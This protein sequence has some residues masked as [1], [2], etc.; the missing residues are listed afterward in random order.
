MKHFIYIVIAVLIGINNIFINY[1]VSLISYERLLEFMIFGMF[2]KSFLDEYRQ[3]GYFRKYTHYI[4]LFAV[5]QLL[6][7]LK[8]V[9]FDNAESKTIFIGFFKCS[10]FL[11]FSYLF[12]LIA[13]ADDKY[14]NI[15][16]GIQVAI[17]FFALAQH[18]VSP[19]S[20]EA[21]N[22]KLMFF[23]GTEDDAELMKNLNN[24]EM[25]IQL[26]LGERFRLSGPFG[27]SISFSYFLISAFL[28][29]LYMYIKT[30]KRIYILTTGLVVVCS[31]LSQTRSL[32]LGEAFILLGVFF[33]V[34]NSKI[35]SYKIIFT[36][37]GLAASLFFINKFDAMFSGG[38][39]SRL[40][41]F[42]DKGSNRPI[43]WLTGLTA[44]ANHPFGVSDDDY[45]IVRRRMYDRYGSQNVL[46]QS[47]HNGLINVGFNYTIF[48]YLAIIAFYI[49]NIKYIR[50]LSKD[51]KYLMLLFIGG[52]SIHALFHN[53]YIFFADYTVLLV[54]MLIPLQ[55]S[56]EN[57]KQNALKPE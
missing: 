25:Y 14:I 29:N 33:L 48:G 2:I 38:E 51:F 19:I 21:H 53:D 30:H 23:K 32:V 13:K 43:L 42:D 24:Q 17:C 6:M 57:S 47:S 44:V 5:L 27:N 49:F 26:G 11:V 41:K 37:L 55:L 45:N 40:T 28:I 39:S 9:A 56:I 8:L 34:H 31:L 20:G 4:L 22:L 18:P 1:K 52:Y 16:I 35:N 36:I 54:Y 7:N 50:K 46:Y 10:S 12:L 3:N 15:V